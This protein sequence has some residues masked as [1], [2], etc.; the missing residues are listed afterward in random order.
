MNENKLIFI[1]SYPKSGNT[2]MRAIVSSLIYSENG[3]FDFELFKKIT[4]LDTNPFYDFV[5]KINHQD[6]LMLDKI[7]T[8]SKY[9]IS[10]QKKYTEL[11]KNFIFKTHAANLMYRNDKYTSEENCK[12]VIYLVRD[13]RGIVPSYAYHLNISNQKSFEI[14][15]DKDQMQ[16]NPRKNI[17][18]PLSSWEVHIK[19][20]EKI[21]TPILFIKYEDLL[22]D[23][24]RIIEECA[25]FLKSIDASF[26]FDTKKI[27]NIYHS[28]KFNRLKKI[29]E[30]N[31]FIIGKDKNFF[32]KGS[33]ENNDLSEEIE[34]KLISE[35]KTKMTEL[36][37]I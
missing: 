33:V 25:E 32:R 11:T 1:A 37:Y 12:G 31:N 29:E 24:I 16:F 9:W 6:F 26:K 30:E 15:T 27:N 13:P 3:V 8:A 34:N 22:C 7:D 5:K 23:T 36:N 28:T 18:V 10:A 14:I 2:F 4:L 20:W 35:F 19:S 17:C 21:N